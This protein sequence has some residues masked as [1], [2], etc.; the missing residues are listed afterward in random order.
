[1]E[2]KLASAGDKLKHT[3]PST[4]SIELNGKLTLLMKADQALIH[5]LKRKKSR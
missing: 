5:T 1:M 2:I 4:E 3:L